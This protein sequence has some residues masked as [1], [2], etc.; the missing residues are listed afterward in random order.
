[1]VGE[2]LVP[3]GQILHS[4]TPSFNISCSD[5]AGWQVG[6]P[7][8]KEQRHYK[9]M[10]VEKLSLP[11]TPGESVTVGVVTRSPAWSDLFTLKLQHR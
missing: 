3:S 9:K 11:F 6:G 1:M 8:A 4:N 10:R 2:L 7:G 5:E